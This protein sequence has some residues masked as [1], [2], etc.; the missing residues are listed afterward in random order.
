MSKGDRKMTSVGITS[1]GYHMPWYRL[2][3]KTITAA[4]G[5]LGKGGGAGDKAVASYDEDSISMAVN[6]GIDCLRYTDKKVDGII[7]ATTTAP[8]RERESAGIIATALDLGSGLRTADFTDSLKSGTAAIAFACDAV[9]AAG[10]GK[11][12]VCGSDC[13]LGSPGSSDEMTVGDGAAAVTIGNENVIASFEGSYSLSYDFPDYRR[14]DR[15]KF[16]RSVE[17]RFAREEGYSKIIPE[18]VKGFLKKYNMEPADFAKVAF[19]CP[20]AREHGAIGTKM[21]FQPAQIAPALASLT[22]DLGAASPLV[23]LVMVLEE[24]KPGDNI[25]V[26]SYGNGAEALYFKVNENIKNIPDRGRFQKS[27]SNTQKLATYEKYLAFRGLLALPIFDEIEGV[28]ELPLVWRSRK[29]IYALHGTKCKVCGTPQYPPQRICVKCSAVDQME[30]YAFGDK[31]TSLFSFT[32]DHASPTINPPLIYGYIDFEG[33]GRYVFELTDCEASSI[34]TGMPMK[35]SFRRKYRDEI[36]G[37]VGYYWK[38]VP[39]R[40]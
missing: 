12:L 15:D 1:Y 23:N 34:K 33:G 21:G 3:R 38:A 5:A 32:I 25:L 22:G 8:Y 4:L 9:R 29:E 19:S 26:V 6:A 18:A 24:A 14:L 17:D 28:T 2:S 7:F 27:L 31:K 10:K 39:G 16:L 40:D 11:Y 30:D 36:R 20:N 37:I 13:R 35:M